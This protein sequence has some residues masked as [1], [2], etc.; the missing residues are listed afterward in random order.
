[1]VH[2]TR[3]SGADGSNSSYEH[4]RN[5]IAQERQ[6]EKE[7][8][9]YSLQKAYNPRDDPRF[10][11]FK[12]SDEAR[13]ALMTVQEMKD[14]FFI[15][16]I[17][18]SGWHEKEWSI[19]QEIRQKQAETIKRLK[20]GA[21]P[22]DF[23]SR[24]YWDKYKDTD[25]PVCR[26]HFNE[27]RE[28]KEEEERH[29]RY[30]TLNACA[31]AERAKNSEARLKVKY[32]ALVKALSQQKSGLLL[33]RPTEPQVD[34]ETGKRYQTSHIWL[35]PENANAIAIEAD[36]LTDVK[37]ARRQRE[38]GD[39]PAMQRRAEHAS[40]LA[41]HLNYE[42]LIALCQYYLGIALYYQDKC[43]EANNAFNAAW[44]CQGHYPEGATLDKWRKRVK[45][46]LQSDSSPS[47]NKLNKG[48]EARLT[49]D[50]QEQE[51]FTST[52]PKSGYKSR[53]MGNLPSL[54]S[55]TVGERPGMRLNLKPI[56]AKP[57]VPAEVRRSLKAV[58]VEVTSPSQVDGTSSGLLSGWIDHANGLQNLGDEMGNETPIEKRE[59]GPYSRSSGLD[60]DGLAQYSKDKL[61]G[62]I[63]GNK[64]IRVKEVVNIERA[65]MPQP[66]RI[67]PPTIAQQANDK[68]RLTMSN[69]IKLDRE[70]QELDADDVRSRLD[71]EGEVVR[72]QRKSSW[73][74]NDPDAWKNSITCMHPP[75][76]SLLPGQR[77][78]RDWPT[79]LLAHLPAE[80]LRPMKD[81]AEDSQ[82]KK[83][84]D[85]FDER[86]E[87]EEKLAA[88]QGLG[89]TIYR[90]GVAYINGIPHI[91][92]E[93]NG[94]LVQQA[95]RKDEERSPIESSSL[96]GG[97]KQI[98][99]VLP[100]VRPERDSNRTYPKGPAPPIPVHRPL[101]KALRDKAIQLST[102]PDSQNS[103]PAVIPRTSE[104]T[105]FERDGKSEV[106]EPSA[107][108][109]RKTQ[110][111]KFSLKVDTGVADKGRLIGQKPPRLASPVISSQTATPP[112]EVQNLPG[113]ERKERSDDEGSGGIGGQWNGEQE[114]AYSREGSKKRRE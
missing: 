3:I 9:N 55:P 43:Q 92:T 2:K 35:H 88:A 4:S 19:L 72:R 81:E 39:F 94:P 83:L 32:H 28:R 36:V 21:Q 24:D 11:F 90:N 31:R 96:E 52:A 53:K 84:V 56:F 95:T 34:L 45:D 91:Q 30:L 104:A 65:T 61:E 50:I 107:R 18:G 75:G 5:V 25:K 57:D 102:K 114:K 105:P 112:E 79:K 98:E 13:E 26:A 101:P 80:A 103:P 1:M 62:K 77:R 37:G 12:S 106:G 78:R 58:S 29:G 44:K 100:P 8:K 54:P 6:R 73:T 74:Y 113:F 22:S 109:R 71:N 85:E 67:Q 63:V 59:H 42:P 93:P 69:K 15:S 64:A 51:N 108:K 87:R 111:G 49:R 17:S 99:E 14:R 86:R 10:S 110:P 27:Y 41:E 76:S 60:T 7:Q 38:R 20:T 66:D 82:I 48:N 70:P 23:E 97:E 89:Q 46:A 16:G 33:G 47:P 40:K 68:T